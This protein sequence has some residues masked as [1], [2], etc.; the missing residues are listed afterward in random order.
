MPFQ[1]TKMAK[2]MNGRTADLG[3]RRLGDRVLEFSKWETETLGG[4]QCGAECG[5]D[6]FEALLAF[7]MRDALH[8][9][10]AIVRV[11]ED[12]EGGGSGRGNSI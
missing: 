12:E 8:A 2:K 4:R 7:E 1:D 5:G 10:A 3:I 9:P 11:P 6:L